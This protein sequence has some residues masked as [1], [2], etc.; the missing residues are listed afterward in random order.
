MRFTDIEIDRLKR[1]RDSIVFWIKENIIP[2]LSG[3]DKFESIEVILPYGM[4]GNKWFFEVMSN[5]K[6]ECSFN[7]GPR[8]ALSDI[9]N[10]DDLWT[11]TSQWSSVKN[12]LLKGIE[13]RKLRSDIINNFEV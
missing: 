8:K 5:G 1:N 12:Q 3:F 4:H 13:E 11:I 10:T 7:V 9:D 2:T 6:I